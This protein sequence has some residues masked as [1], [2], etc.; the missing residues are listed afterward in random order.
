MSYRVRKQ[1]IS[2]RVLLILVAFA[3]VAIGSLTSTQPAVAAGDDQGS[4]DSRN[5]TGSF[6]DDKSRQVD[7]YSGSSGSGSGASKGEFCDY[8]D[9][10]KPPEDVLFCMLAEDAAR[11]AAASLT[12]PYNKPQFG[13]NPNQNQWDMIPVGFPIW[14]WTSSTQTSLST[15]ATTAGLTVNLSLTRVKVSFDMADGHKISCTT[16]T[17][18]PTHLYDNPMRPSPTCGYTYKT[19]GE[20][21]ITAT[22]TW[23]VSWQAGGQAGSFQINDTTTSAPFRIGQ[24]VT[25][26]VDR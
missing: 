21:T 5:S 14:L 3:L 18:R 20:Y 16:F 23:A 8:T 26:L 17:T 25:V 10:G 1:S 11:Q 2:V 19:T 15:S 24:L 6:Y 13:P 22:T 12:L 7:V 9:S 4:Y